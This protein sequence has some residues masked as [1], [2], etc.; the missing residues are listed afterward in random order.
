MDIKEMVGKARQRVEEARR[1][2][3]EYAGKAMPADVK[4]QVDR[5]LEEARELKAQADRAVEVQKLQAW[6]DEP[7]YRRP[8]SE[9]A[10][11]ALAPEDRAVG[12]RRA[13]RG[14][15]EEADPGVL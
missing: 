3:E 6:L 9:G 1:I 4:Q 14:A 12:G 10:V 8:M 5:L 13:Q 11:K 2:V 7:Q 15:E